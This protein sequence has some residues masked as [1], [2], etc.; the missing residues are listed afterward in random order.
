M[1]W[2]DKHVEGFVKDI[3]GWVN[4]WVAV[5]FDITLRTALVALPSRRQNFVRR[6]GR[7]EF[8]RSLRPH[9]SH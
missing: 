8:E 3:I 1:L 5:E 6:V 4:M 2:L 9:L 7:L